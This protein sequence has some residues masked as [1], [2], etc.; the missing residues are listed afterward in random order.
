MKDDRTLA[1]EMTDEIATNI[2]HH[3][4]IMY[5]AMWVGVPKTARISLRNTI[6]SH[7]GPACGA[8]QAKIDSLMLEYCPDE[9]TPQQAENWCK[10]Q[11]PLDEEQTLKIERAIKKLDLPE[12]PRNKEEL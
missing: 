8:L 9:M 11:R 5:P 10:H 7:V 3:I 12:P 2:L 1:E 4:D 6:L